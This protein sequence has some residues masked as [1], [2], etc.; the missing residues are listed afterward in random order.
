M[1]R[2]RWRSRGVGGRSRVRRRTYRVEVNTVTRT[3]MT[4][5]TFGRDEW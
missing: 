4:T 5:G 1:G 2:C 3:E